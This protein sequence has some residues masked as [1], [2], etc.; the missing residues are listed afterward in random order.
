MITTR[1]ERCVVYHL[2]TPGTLNLGQFARVLDVN[3]SSS[4]SVP[5]WHFKAVQ[6]SSSLHF[7]RVASQGHLVK[8]NGTSTATV[9]AF[10]RDVANYDGDPSTMAPIEGVLLSNGTGTVHLQTQPREVGQLWDSVGGIKT[11]RVRYSSLSGLMTGTDQLALWRGTTIESTVSTDGA[12]LSLDNSSGSGIAVMGAGVDAI[13]YYFDQMLRQSESFKLAAFALLGGVL[14]I[15]IQTPAAAAPGCFVRL[16]ADL[17][18]ASL[19]S[20]GGTPP[21]FVPSLWGPS[22]VCKGVCIPATSGAETIIVRI[23]VLGGYWAPINQRTNIKAQ[24]FGL[25]VQLSLALQGAGTLSAYKFKIEALAD[26]PASPRQNPLW[27]ETLRRPISGQLPRTVDFLACD[28]FAKQIALRGRIPWAKMPATYQGIH[29]PGGET[30]DS[31]RCLWYDHSGFKLMVD[32]SNQMSYAGH[33]GMRVWISV[34]ETERP[35]SGVEAANRFLHMEN[36]N[37]QWV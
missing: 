35:G 14:Q 12:F 6:A 2:D 5:W 16:L 15:T 28:G 19:S 29:L 31:P 20:D 30:F 18:G 34:K 32:H 4:S 23:P 17:S 8:L 24:A 7:E 10:E 21:W 9:D 13:S 11:E 33:G 26:L 25:G 27:S 37:D 36:P 1:M 3:L 22:S